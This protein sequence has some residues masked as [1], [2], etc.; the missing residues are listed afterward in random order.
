M[1][2]LPPRVHG[3]QVVGVGPGGGGLAAGPPAAAV[4]GVQGAADPM[5]HQPLGAAD[6]KRQPGG[7]VEHDAPHVGV[8]GDAL[9]QRGRD[10]ADPVQPGRLGGP[11]PQLG[12]RITR[13]V[14]LDGC[15]D[16]PGWPCRLVR[17]P[18][19]R[20]GRSLRGSGRWPCGRAGAARVAPA[21]SVPVS[22]PVV[23]EVA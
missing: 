1:L 22:V 14:R 12:Q 3:L 2:V 9:G 16:L 13:P 4:A 7:R 8:A 5:W 21:G 23:V 19:C 20:A 10:L 17:P 6:V 11:G 15:V 18:V